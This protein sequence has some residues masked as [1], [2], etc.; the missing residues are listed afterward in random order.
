MGLDGD[1]G[2]SGCDKVKQKVENM[3]L[4]LLFLIR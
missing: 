1:V 4:C 2:G 3:F